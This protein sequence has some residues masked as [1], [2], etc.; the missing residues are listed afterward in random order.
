MSADEPCSQLNISYLHGS[1]NS[2]NYTFPHSV[3][4]TCN[5]GYWLTRSKSLLTCNLSGDWNPLP[6]PCK[7]VSCPKPN[8]TSLENSG[9]ISEVKW[10]H[11]VTHTIINKCFAGYEVSKGMSNSTHHCLASHSTSDGYWDQ[12]FKKCQRISCGDLSNPDNGWVKTES[13][14]FGS[15]A[16]YGCQEGCNLSSYIRRH[17]LANGMWSGKPPSCEGTLS[18]IF[19]KRFTLSTSDPTIGP[20]LISPRFLSEC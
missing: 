12:P 4:L 17:C 19:P 11:G 9:E 5:P 14:L 8:L 13:I 16:T 1:V 3:Q 15:S 6:T 2:T 7:R 18:E 10:D 20:R